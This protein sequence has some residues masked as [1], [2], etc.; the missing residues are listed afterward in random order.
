MITLQW[1]G[2]EDLYRSLIRIE[3]IIEKGSAELV[4][5]AAEALVN[6]I[7]SNWS[8]TRQRI[9]AGNPPAIKT[10]NLDSSIFIEE[11]G[12]DVL[13]RF[14]DANNTRVKFV[15]IDTS[16]GDDPQGRGGY[17]QAL[18]DTTYYNLPFMQPE[19]DAISGVYGDMAKRH[20]RL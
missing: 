2:E 8:A 18:E 7:R 20:M 12:R 14:A 16:M 3:S 6:H 5:D 4:E 1:K 19:I 11:S 10:G 17:S 9:G 15:R 13:G